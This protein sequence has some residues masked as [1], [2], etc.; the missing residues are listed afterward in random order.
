MN[1][2]IKV[3]NI[4]KSWGSKTK[5]EGIS[6]VIMNLYRNMNHDN[7]QFHVA[8][9]NLNDSVF[10]DEIKSYG[11]NVFNLYIAGE[12]NSKWNICKRLIRLIN[13][14]KYDA[15]YIHVSMG[16]DAWWMIP[17]YAFTKTPLRIV[18]SHNAGV[19]GTR[20]DKVRLL[21]NTLMKPILSFV[22]TDFFACSSTAAQW[23]FTKNAFSKKGR[24]IKNAISINDFVF[25]QSTRDK[26]RQKFDWVDTLVLGNVGRISY[27]KNQEFL[28][29]ILLEMKKIRP[30]KLIMIGGGSE[31]DV[32]R[33]KAKISDVNLEDD[34][35]YLGLRTDVSDYLN[36]MDCFIFPSRYEG[37]G[38][39][40]VE[41]QANSLPTICSTKV[42]DEAKT[43][44]LFCKVSLDRPVQEWCALILSKIEN[45][46]R[47]DMSA[48]LVNGGY[49]ILSVS[50]DLEK[51]LLNEVYKNG[52]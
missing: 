34:V 21:L 1:N 8:N 14:N 50:R 11:G 13:N 10:D 31:G 9:I 27:Q 44:D 30:T 36:A 35:F 37:L 38:I 46:E 48:D 43:T 4:T 29:D 6:T 5:I 7:I 2:P 15:V 28:L 39:T 17:V 3:L 24:I 22:C 51:Y 41:A 26:I 12:N 52:K 32:A 33:L 23:A 16:Y 45:S 40:A 19:N 49:D 18:H 20:G 42:P 25:S 47:K